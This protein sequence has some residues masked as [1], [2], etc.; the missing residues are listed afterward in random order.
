VH[1]PVALAG[2]LNTPP[3]EVAPV[4]LLTHNRTWLAE[5]PLP[6][7]ARRW[8]AIDWAA[9]QRAPPFVDAWGVQE[10]GSTLGG[11]CDAASCT[12]SNTKPKTRC[13]YILYRGPVS[14]LQSAV[15]GTAAP[16]AS[17]TPPSDHR[18][19]VSTVRLEVP[20]P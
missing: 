18:A 17:G 19:V 4:A 7:P 11:P 10:P 12:F 5:H 6:P 1:A 16:D 14:A 13:D 3:G 9:L 2:D 15:A 20:P 8:P